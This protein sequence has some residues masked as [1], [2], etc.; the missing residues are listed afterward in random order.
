MQSTGDITT[1][2]RAASG[3]D[4]QASAS[5]FESVYKELR[6]IAQAQRR[7]WSG[8]ETLSATALINEA[9]LRLV[10][11]ELGDYQDRTHFFATASRAMRHVLI[12]Y[13][14]QASAAKRGS[15]QVRVTLTGLAID[16]EQTLDDLIDI[17]AALEQLEQ[18]N[19]RHCR[20]F[21]CRVFG[22]MTIEETA[23]AVGVSPATVKRDWSLVSAY[24]YSE[25]SRTAQTEPGD[26]LE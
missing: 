23:S 18:T 16:Q 8:N 17:G 20:L 14:E 15:D 19:P 22:G 3:G 5:L 11:D 13:A 4:Q 10:K 12:N 25:L 21:E 26:H 2:L 6:E 9:Y 7:K 1:L 24:I